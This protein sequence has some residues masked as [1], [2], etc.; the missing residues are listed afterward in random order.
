MAKEEKT[1]QESSNFMLKEYEIISSAFFDLSKQKTEM[2]RFYLILVTIPVTLIAAIIGLENQTLSFFA[3]P[4]LVNLVLLAVSIAGLLMS[5]LIVDLRFEAI[6]YAKTVNLARRFFVDND[7]NNLGKYTL[8]PDGDDYPKFN[9]QPW[10][11]KNR[12]WK[13]KFGTGAS[14]LE[15]L[16]M[17]LLN[18]VYFGSAM[19]NILTSIDYLSTNF[20][21]L[22]VV[23]VIFSILFFLAHLIG[24][25]YIANK[26]DSQWAPK[27]ASTNQSELSQPANFS[28][29]TTLS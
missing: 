26:R 11:I 7:K 17:A 29:T 6:A 18:A 20:A 15:V 14:F 3:L 4:D 23:S 9:E 28:K 2:F 27:I 8:L 1:G 10:S 19:V 5:A 12:Q 21:A 22:V 16:L 24:Y 13:W 25:V